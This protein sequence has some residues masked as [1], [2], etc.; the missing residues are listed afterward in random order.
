M[1]RALAILLGLLCW[2][3]VACRPPHSANHRA[4]GPVQIFQAT[5]LLKQVMPDGNTAV[6]RHDAIPNYMPAMTMSFRVRSP[7]E[8]TGLRAGDQLS[9]RL[10]V[11][12]Q[13][14]WIDR[15]SLRG[16][17]NLIAERSEKVAKSSLAGAS[18]AHPLMSYPFTNQF[19][20][21]V[22]LASFRGQA[23]AI[24]FF[25]TRC[26]I[27]EYCPRLSKN[28]Q[29]AS[30][31]LASLPGA[32]ANWHFLSVS[33]DPQNDTPAVLTVYA[34]R[35]HADPQRWSFLT[36]PVEKVRELAEQ[37]GVT[38]EPENGLLNHNFRTLIIDAA[39]QLQTSFPIGGN[40]SD[41]IVTEIVKAANPKP[42]EGNASGP[43][44]PGNS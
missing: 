14:S 10:H 13:E 36:G 42:P 4:Q 23:L 32:P 3:M 12:E 29:E 41:S 28:F 37:S 1:K 38:Y 5:G 27:P 35:Y 19:G 9:F 39:G 20:K 40:L 11:A 22:T 33:I 21:P 24:T 26:P 15:I 31:K 17:T 18:P 43:K 34:K 2:R 8:L 6:I 16:R 7:N 44:P 25:F 30:A